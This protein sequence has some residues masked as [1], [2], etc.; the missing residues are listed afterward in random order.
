MNSLAD[1]LRMARE[2]AG[3]SSAA[4]AAEAFGWKYPTYSAHENGTR[5]FGRE[6][7]KKYAEIYRV[8]LDWLITGRGAPKG[9]AMIPLVGFVG[10]GAEILPIDD[11]PKGGGLD[12]IPAPAGHEGSS[13]AVEI[14]GD[15]MFPL[16]PG[17]RLV[18]ARERDGVPMEAL[19]RL[20]VCRL[21]DGRMLVKELQRGSRKG[22]YRLV[23]WNAAPIEDVA[24]EWAALVLE[25]RLS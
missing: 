7:A 17:W 13:V 21:R 9:K 2:L 18:Y 4:G 15:S 22:V 14:R 10:A 25:I 16:K 8:S 1:R 24:L 19:N 6:K 3:Y 11:H 5:G 23:S 20:C 12:E